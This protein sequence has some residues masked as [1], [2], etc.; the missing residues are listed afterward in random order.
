MSFDVVHLNGRLLPRSE[1]KV[2]VDDR[3]FLLGDGLF[4][5]MRAYQGRPAFLG[6][7]LARLRHGAAAMRLALPDD[8]AARVAATLAAN[9]MPDCAVRVTVTRGP[10]GRG[11]SPRGAGPPTVL[12]ALSPIPYAEELYSCGLA[13]VTAP[14]PPSLGLKATSYAA[15]VLAR[16][17]ADD[18]GADEAILVDGTGALLEATQANVFLVRGDELLTPPAVGVLPGVTRATLL[19]IAPEAGLTPREARLTPADAR[20][21]D[22]ALLCA[23]VLEVAPV[24]SL[25]GAPLRRGDVADRL[26]RLYRLHATRSGETSPSEGLKHHVG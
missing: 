4:E 24:A 26:R 15:H 14:A 1:A 18:A 9:G 2:G 5:T 19:R 3:G 6:E 7:H 23:S 12:V 8:L 16:I 22:E 11:A 20:G 25:D 21:A 10:G 17:A 13:A